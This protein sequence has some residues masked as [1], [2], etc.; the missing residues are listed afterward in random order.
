MTA[1]QYPFF[2]YLFDVYAILYIYIYI[3]KHE[4][5]LN[6]VYVWIITTID[7]ELCHLIE[8]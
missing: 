5:I 7:I 2:V 3:Y 1:S 4:F 6:F 8:Y